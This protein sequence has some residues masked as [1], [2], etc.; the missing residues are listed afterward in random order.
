MAAHRIGGVALLAVLLGLATGG[1]AMADRLDDARKKV[2]AGAVQEALDL[3]RREMDEHPENA[4]AYRLAAECSENLGDRK[5]A[6]TLWGK[7]RLLAKDAAERQYARDR[8]AA[9]ASSDGPGGTSTPLPV[10]TSSEFDIDQLEAFRTAVQ[11]WS[12]V[13]TEHFTVKTHNDKLAEYVAARAE[14]YLVTL[15]QTFLGGGLYPHKVPLTVYRDHAEYVAAGN[16]QWSG[17]GTMVGKAIDEK[18]GVKLVRKIDFFQ[19]LQDGALNPELV[20]PRVIPHELTHLVLAEYFGDSQHTVPR[21]FQE[22]IAQWVEAGTREQADEEVSNRIVM[23]SKYYIPLVTL[24]ELMDY[25][26]D[27]ST[28]QAFYVESASFMGFV[29]DTFTREKIFALINEYKK[30]SRGADAFRN[31][32]GIGEKDMMQRMQK[33]WL[34]RLFSKYEGKLGGK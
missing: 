24:V 13:E 6:R 4:P 8:E 22:G 20:K 18:L 7:Y 14:H 9:C 34:E 30:G 12:T 26:P 2:E 21:W 17:G 23:G 11:A 19:L 25:P 1:R 32:L 27:R 16:P 31:V 5:G 28:I 33:Q 10:A 3:C 29:V 15:L